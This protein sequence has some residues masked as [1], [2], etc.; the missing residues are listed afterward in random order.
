MLK[1]FKPNGCR[2]SGPV[3]LNLSPSG[4]VILGKNVHFRPYC[5]L[6]IR[7][8]GEIN[9][10]S[11]CRLD[12]GVRIVV[13]KNYLVKLGENVEIGYGSLVNAGQNILVGKGSAI[14]ANCILQSS[15]HI[16]SQNQTESVT[17]GH[18]FRGP[19]TLGINTWLASFVLVRPETNLGDASVYGAF[20]LVQGIYP[21]NTMNAGIPAVKKKDI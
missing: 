4:R 3:I 9:I 2:A 6:K 8:D 7:D 16:I 17:G 19:I 11:N 10:G 12:F 13:A 14:G 1:G 21:S 15:E 5:E 18:Y 20:S